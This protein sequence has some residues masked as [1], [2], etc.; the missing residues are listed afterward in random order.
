MFYTVCGHRLRRVSP[1]YDRPVTLIDQNL[2]VHVFEAIIREGCAQVILSPGRQRTQCLL[3]DVSSVPE[4]GLKVHYR[5]SSHTLRNKLQ[6]VVI[7]DIKDE[8]RH[9]GWPS[10]VRHALTETTASYAIRSD[11]LSP[12][13]SKASVVRIYGHS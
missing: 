10:K 13:H 11:Y 4:R 2:A 6:F 7:D 8:K 1:S 12:K 5:R 9:C 3:H